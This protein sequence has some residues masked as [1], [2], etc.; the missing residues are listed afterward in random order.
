MTRPQETGR[1]LADDPGA[2]GMTDFD[3]EQ[4]EDKYA[5]YFQE[6]QRAYKNAFNQMNDRYESDLIHG[7]DQM[8]L[9]ESEPFYKD[10]EF[11]VELPENPQ[12]RLQGVLVTDEK[13]EETLE[14]YVE[15]IESELHR[16]FGVEKP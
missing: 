1:L 11:V 12:E 2:Y 5:N 6:L 9:N 7:I 13:F 8:I 14:T 16:V 10:G 4:F 3:P 15:T